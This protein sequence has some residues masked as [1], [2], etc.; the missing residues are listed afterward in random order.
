MNLYLDPGLD[1][2]APGRSGEPSQLRHV[3]AC[4]LL[5]LAAAIGLPGCDWQPGAER[6]SETPIEKPNPLGLIPATE[7]DRLALRDPPMNNNTIVHFTFG[8]LTW[9]VPRKLIASMRTLRS[10]LPADLVTL[11]LSWSDR[12]LLGADA[13]GAFLIVY[14]QTYSD[15]V[16]PLVPLRREKVSWVPISGLEPLGLKVDEQLGIAGGFGLLGRKSEFGDNPSIDCG[17]R[18]SR[19]ASRREI[20]DAIARASE[21]HAQC[22]GSIQLN[23]QL[24]MRFQFPAKYALEYE[25]IYDALMDKIEEMGS[26]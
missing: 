13:D 22:D 7:A 26:E 8:G 16:D 25:L 14:L 19:N 2:I 1:S 11:H 20:E 23:E 9:S 18:L 24:Y 17:F 10:S 12:K 21:R 5:A 6:H 15:T 3:Y 4:L